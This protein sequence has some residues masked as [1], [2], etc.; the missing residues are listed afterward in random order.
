[1]RIA[2]A[3]RNFEV[4]APVAP[5]V[6]A[7][8]SSFLKIP[9]PPSSAVLWLRRSS[10]ATMMMICDNDDDENDDPDGDDDNDEDQV[11][12]KTPR[13]GALSYPMELARS[14]ARAEEKREQPLDDDRACRQLG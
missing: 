13:S 9:S 2:A 11:A 1:M 14:V 3:A 8:A 12:P 4:A 5:V 7:G 10:S 6:P